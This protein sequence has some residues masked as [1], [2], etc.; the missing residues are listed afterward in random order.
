MKEEKKILGEQRRKLILQWLKESEQPLTGAELAAKTNV[1][2]QVIVQDISLLK[3]RNEPIIATSQGY[4]YLP[5]NVPHETYTRVVACYHAPEQTK[6]ELQ[7]IVD[8]GVTVKDVKIEHPVYGDLTASVMVSNR[9]EVEQFIQK[10]EETN[11]SYLLQ[12]TDGTHLHT[13]EADSIAKL[14]AACLAL[15]KAGFLIES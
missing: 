10:I 9:L 4:L 8:H 5:T 12:L 7:L 13:L 3:A 14:D 11:S 2:R 15:K 6:E 1:S